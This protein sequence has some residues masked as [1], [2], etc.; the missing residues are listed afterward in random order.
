MKQKEI[1]TIYNLWSGGYITGDLAMHRIGKVLKS[2][3]I[4]N[5]KVMDTTGKSFGEIAKMLIGYD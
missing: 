2:I 4:K 3:E 1:Q 5:V